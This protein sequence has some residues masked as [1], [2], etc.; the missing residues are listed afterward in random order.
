MGTLEAHPGHSRSRAQT[1]AGG[2]ACR[3]RL[4]VLAWGA[5]EDSGYGAVTVVAGPGLEDATLC[6]LR[7]RECFPVSHGNAVSVCH[8]D[9]CGMYASG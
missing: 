3:R 8:D 1:V 6:A 4:S 7:L 5:G 2:L 9:T